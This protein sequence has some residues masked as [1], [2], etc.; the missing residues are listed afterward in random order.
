[1][2]N[3]L[4]IVSLDQPKSAY[5]HTE[6]ALPATSNSTGRQRRGDLKQVIT[7]ATLPNDSNHVLLELDDV[8][9]L[10]EFTDPTRP[11]LTHLEILLRC[12]L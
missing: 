7:V 8:S 9:S 12:L 1:M 10:A 3:Q 6:L 5:N 4:S 2:Y 11:A